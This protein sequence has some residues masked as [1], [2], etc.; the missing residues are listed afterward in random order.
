MDRGPAVGEEWVELTH[1][2]GGQAADDVVEVGERSDAVEVGGADKAEEAGGGVVE[3]AV[4][5]GVTRW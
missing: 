4:P 3:P 5:V 1:R 2:C